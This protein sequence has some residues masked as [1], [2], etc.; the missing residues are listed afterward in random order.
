[1]EFVSP[2]HAADHAIVDS[3]SRYGFF[4][5]SGDEMGEIERYLPE[6]EA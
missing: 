5:F 6:V 2:M 3:G 1:M 4:I